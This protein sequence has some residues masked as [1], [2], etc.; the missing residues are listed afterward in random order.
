MEINRGSTRR[1]GVILCIRCDL[2]VSR[3]PALTATLPALPLSTGSGSFDKYRQIHLNITSL[4]TYNR[5]SVQSSPALPARA[6]PPVVRV[7]CSV[8]DVGSLDVT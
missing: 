1:K 4:T 8:F 6:T 7:C 2:V 3:A 5:T